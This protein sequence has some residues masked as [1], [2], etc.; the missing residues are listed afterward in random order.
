MDLCPR[1][2]GPQDPCEQLGAAMIEARPTTVTVQE[3]LFALLVVK[4]W[5]CGAAT[6]SRVTDDGPWPYNVV[7]VYASPREVA[8][9]VADESELPLEDD[10]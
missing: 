8:V 3:G 6:V 2:Q 9:P 1:C 10:V 5:P 4:V 7:D